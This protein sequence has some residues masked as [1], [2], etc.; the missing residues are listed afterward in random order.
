M[1]KKEYAARNAQWLAD[2]AVEPGVKPIGGGVLC[3]VIESGDADGRQ[4]NLGSVVVVNYSGRTI[5]GHVFD[6]SS[7][8]VTA[9]ALRLRDLIE[10]WIIA[11]TQ[12]HVGDVW[13]IYIPSDKAYG[14]RSQPGI[15]G[16]STLIFKIELVG[17][18]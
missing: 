18:G 4:P 1:S 17:V 5:D 10:G 6:S 16:N 8:S 2:K 9:P 3:R 12:M 15:P 7:D 13:E 11:L 14:K